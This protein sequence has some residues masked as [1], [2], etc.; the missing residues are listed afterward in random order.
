VTGFDCG[1]GNVLIDTWAAR[2][3]RESFDRDGDWAAGGRSHAALLAALLDEPYFRLPPPKSTGRDLFNAQWLDRK[4]AQRNIE[5]RDVQA[6]LT[7]LT[8]SCIGAAVND[9]FPRAADVVVC[10]GG[11]FNQ[12]LLRMLAEECAPRQ[13]TTTAALDVAPEHVEALAI[14][15][16]AREHLLRRPA[17]LP[18][19]TGARGPRILGALY[20]A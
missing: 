2:H 11:A 12:T 20:P 8:A 3:L 5:P 1:P 14:A 13:V 7:R 10:G 19:V 6:T 17:S 15:W 18:A 4:L 16:L 9:Y